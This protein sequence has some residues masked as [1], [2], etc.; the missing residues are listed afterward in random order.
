[1]QEID[2]IVYMMVNG[3][4]IFWSALALN[5]KTVVPMLLSFVCWIVDAIVHFSI[6]YD[7]SLVS[8]SYLYLGFGFVFLFLTFDSAFKLAGWR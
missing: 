6:F 8:V 3:L 7:S 2:L 5:R 4:S 1:V